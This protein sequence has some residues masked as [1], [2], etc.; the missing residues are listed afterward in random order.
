[1]DT[2]AISVSQLQD[3]EA[4]VA[5]WWAYKAIVPVMTIEAAEAFNEL[6]DQARKA[7]KVIR[8]V[9]GAGS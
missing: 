6:D 2:L 8:E 7:E 1:M 4:L 5:K 9:R 3:L